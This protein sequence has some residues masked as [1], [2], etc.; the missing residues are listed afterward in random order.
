MGLNFCNVLN[1]SVSPSIEI[2]YINPAPTDRPKHCL[3]L[4]DNNNC[5]FN[6]ENHENNLTEVQ[7][8]AINRFCGC[9]LATLSIERLARLKINLT[10]RF[11][12]FGTY[13]KDLLL[14]TW[15]FSRSE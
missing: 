9:Q 5:L 2:I 1:F 7:D 3:S 12:F 15:A 4:N 11:N 10:Q 8:Q 6:K 13:K 14:L